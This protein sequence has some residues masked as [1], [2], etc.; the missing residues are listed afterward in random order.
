MCVCRVRSKCLACLSGLIEKVQRDRLAQVNIWDEVHLNLLVPSFL[1]HIK[2][3]GG[4]TEY[5]TDFV[6]AAGITQLTPLMAA[7]FE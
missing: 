7:I 3:E 1:Y 2:E 4:S 5:M 6:R